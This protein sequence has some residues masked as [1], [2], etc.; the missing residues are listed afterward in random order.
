MAQVYRCERCKGIYDEK[1]HGVIDKDGIRYRLKIV[2]DNGP[3]TREV[4]VDLCEKCNQ[5]LI[6]FASNLTVLG[7]NSP[8]VEPIEKSSR[9]SRKGWFGRRK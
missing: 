8:G 6:D 1:I 7:S 4:Y 2:R 3:Y 9:K 5:L